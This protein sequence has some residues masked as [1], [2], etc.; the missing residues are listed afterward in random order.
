MT[1]RQQTKTNSRQSK[2]PANPLSDLERY[3]PD[4][5]SNHAAA[6]NQPKNLPVSPLGPP[7]RIQNAPPVPAQ[8][9]LVESIQ[10]P[11]SM[12]L[13]Q[14]EAALHEARETQRQLE[15]RNFELETA[16]SH[17][18]RLETELKE[19][20]AAKLEL[21][22]QIA[23]LE[24]QVKKVQDTDEALTAERHQRIQLEKRLATLEVRAERAQEMAAQLAEIQ[25]A[26]VHLEREK[27]TL[28]V[29]V[30]SMQKLDKLLTEERQARMNAQSRASSAEAQL[31]R[32]EGELG[33]Q[34]ASGRGSLM[35]RLRGH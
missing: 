33:N 21:I 32:L 13:S 16:V 19:E 17:T 30:Q 2:Q 6:D 35:N 3:D 14:L 28:E 7:Q 15:R 31:A 5:L 20:R 26:R 23:A 11:G 27:A 22:K 34:G 12:R 10:Q 8:P 24:V 25:T 4:H 9:Q 1:K 29:Q 18:A